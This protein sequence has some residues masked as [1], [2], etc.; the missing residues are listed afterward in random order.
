MVYCKAAM[1]V[2]AMIR[3]GSIVTVMIRNGN[4]FGIRV[5]GLGERWF[6]AFVNI[7]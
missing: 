3:V 5:S 4:M 1:D 2:G 6:I 7:S